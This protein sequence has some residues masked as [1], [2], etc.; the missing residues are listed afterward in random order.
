[1]TQPVARYQAI[2]DRIIA[3]NDRIF[4]ELIFFSPMRGSVQDDKRSAR[5]IEGVLR[6]GG[7]SET[8]VANRQ[9][10]DWR[11][12]I[13]AG[14]GEL[15]IDWAAFPGLIVRQGDRLRAMTR[16][17]VPWF[18]VLAVDDRSFDRLVLQLGEI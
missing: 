1:M 13:V 7:G 17:E 2:R 9:A 5:N 16:P 8:S 18:E 6:V 4:A 14:K 11:S 15:H 10:T 3:A 12:R